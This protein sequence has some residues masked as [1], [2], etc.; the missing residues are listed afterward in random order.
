MGRKTSLSIRV[1]VAGALHN[2]NGMTIHS[3]NPL[4]VLKPVL[5]VSSV[6]TRMLLYPARMS[7]L[8]NSDFPRSSSRI[9]DILGSGVTSRTDTGT[10]GRKPTSIG[11]P[12]DWGKFREPAHVCTK[13]Q[14]IP[15]ASLE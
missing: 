4:F 9:D 10:W 12:T 5:Y 2:P 11:L 6:V 8:L 3:N 15:R 7:N 13:R 14:K 1:K